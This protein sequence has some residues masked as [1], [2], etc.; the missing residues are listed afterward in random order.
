[1]REVFKLPA[2]A[3]HSNLVEMC[4][5]VA[6]ETSLLPFEELLRKWWMTGT[7]IMKVHLKTGVPGL[8]TPEAPAA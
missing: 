2:F 1:M 4:L 3:K 8:M 6:A 5:D 7:V